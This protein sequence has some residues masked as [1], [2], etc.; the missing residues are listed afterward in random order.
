MT[1]TVFG[2]LFLIRRVSDNFSCCTSYFQL[3]IWKCVQTRSVL[4]D[5][6]HVLQTLLQNVKYQGTLLQLRKGFGSRFY[7]VFLCYVEQISSSLLWQYQEQQWQYYQQWI[8]LSLFCND[9]ICR[10]KLSVNHTCTWN[11]INFLLDE[12]HLFAFAFFKI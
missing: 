2:Y 8:C 12:M 5:I 3:S 7:I 10:G 9:K 4:F 11:L 1:M 6:L